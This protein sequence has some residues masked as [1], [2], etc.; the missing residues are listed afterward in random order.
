MHIMFLVNKME[1]KKP[2]VELK[3][4]RIL[5]IDLK[6]IIA[7]YNADM[8]KKGTSRV[9][10]NEKNPRYGNKP[11]IG[12][13]VDK[14]GVEYAVPYTSG[15]RWHKGYDKVDET[16]GCLLTEI[17][18]TR[19]IDLTEGNHKK[20]IVKQLP[21]NHPYFENHPDIPD[22]EKQYFREHIKNFLDF[23]RMIPLAKGTYKDYDLT[24]HDFNQ[25]KAVEL[26]NDQ[27]RL[28][29]IHQTLMEKSESKRWY[30]QMVEGKITSNN[31]PD[32]RMLNKTRILWDEYK[33]TKPRSK[34]TAFLKH[35]Y[36]TEDVQKAIQIK[37]E[38]DAAKA[39]FD[40]MIE[41]SEYF[42]KADEIDDVIEKP[43]PNQY[44]E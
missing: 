15:K 24:C 39:K 7:L 10:Y 12:I 37:D 8:D 36:G 44:G 13:F 1:E 18:D 4:L 28:A 20:W 34:F 21:E 25:I 3:E 30:R 6:Y 19:E 32:L 35:Q 43:E 17:I 29:S 31:E 23:E 16:K 42:C 9:Y 38:R 14:N 33:E 5:K 27:F 26:L 22:E 2:G 11:Y 40:K 41:N